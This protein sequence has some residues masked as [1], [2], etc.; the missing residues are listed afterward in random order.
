MAVKKKADTETSS[1]GIHPAALALLKD[2]DKEYS[3]AVVTID[4][5]KFDVHRVPTGV[6][7]L[8]K[9]LDGG[10]PIGKLIEIF[11][12]EMSGKTSLALQ[13]A[14]TVMFLPENLDKLVLF[15]DAETS[16]DHDMVCEKYGLDP[17]RVRIVRQ[18]SEIHAEKIL[19]IVLAASSNPG[20]CLVILDSIA[21]LIPMAEEEKSF[22]QG[23]MAA[24][25]AALIHRACRK[26]FRDGTLCPV[27]F[28]NQIQDKIGYM[29]HGDSTTTPGGKGPKFYASLRLK[30]TRVK[31]LKPNKDAAPS[32]FVVQAKAV[33]ARY[34]RAEQVADFVVD[35]ALGIDTVMSAAT[36]GI[37]YG[38]V[39]KS[40]AWLTLFE[41]R[42]QGMPAL[43]DALRADP[44]LLADLQNNLEL[45]AQAG[46]DGGPETDA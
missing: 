6:H 8:D 41:Q 11:G 21:A 19:D 36:L 30:L 39:L 22:E 32:G 23:S 2:F 7:S 17:K 43:C 27:I 14:K 20:F 3:G 29:G 45:A 18:S 26:I 5:P 46:E 13:A 10:L 12:P 28:L 34:S 9:I 40:G 25:R 24:T 33:K 35:Y 44:A 15:A 31:T 42:Y 4:N 38:I 16:L 37:Q 1:G